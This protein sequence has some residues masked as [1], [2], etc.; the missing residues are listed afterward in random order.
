MSLKSTIAQY[1]SRTILTVVLLIFACACL[2]LSSCSNQGG[3]NINTGNVATTTSSPKTVPGEQT[4]STQEVEE[5]KRLNPED[6]LKEIRAR[7]RKLALDV[8]DVILEK[9]REEITHQPFLADPKT[10]PALEKYS[11]LALTL[12]LL[13][14]QK[15]IYGQDNRKDV[16]LVSSDP[17]INAAADAVVSLF[18]SNRLAPLEDGTRTKIINKVFVTEYRLCDTSSPV[19]PYLSQPCSAFCSGVLVAPDIIATAGHCINTPA[20]GTPPLNEIRFVFGYRMRDENTPQLIIDNSEVYTGKQII[21]QVY[22]PDGADWAL[23]RLDRPVQ[24]HMPVSI[25]RT[26]KI[27]DADDLYVIG[28]PCGLPAKF[29]DGA[30]VRANTDANFFVANLDTYG[31]NSGSPVFNRMTHQ[32][33][34]L[35]VR[36]EKDFVVRN[37]SQSNSCRISL[38]CPT[39]GCRGEDCTRTTLFAHLVPGP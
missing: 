21:K 34:G 24:G 33:E 6:L 29:A 27:S 31:G 19:E 2:L 11:S 9:R 10:D 23:V 35:L 15:A 13:D 20:A 4:V 38:R 36:G 18:R 16:F 22:A 32:V 25:R 14:S 26:A 3:S 17:K 28:H 5:L 1:V 8:P 37:P 7:E 39:T 12:A 30:I